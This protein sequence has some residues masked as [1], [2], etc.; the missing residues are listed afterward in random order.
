MHGEE[1]LNKIFVGRLAC[2]IRD[3]C[4]FDVV[5][6]TFTHLSISRVYN[7]STHK[8]DLNIDDRVR[9][10]LL[11]VDTEELFSAPRHISNSGCVITARRLSM[12]ASD[13]SAETPV[14][15]TGQSPNRVSVSVTHQRGKRTN[16]NQRQR[17]QHLELWLRST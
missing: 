8:S 5:R 6:I 9:L 15:W 2:V 13:T 14:Q 16:S 11:E 4:D 3:L 1:E 7:V 12:A 10:Q 17:L